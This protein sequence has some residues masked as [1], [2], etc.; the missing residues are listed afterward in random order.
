LCE[1]N[2]SVSVRLN[3]HDWVAPTASVE[4][5]KSWVFSLKSLPSADPMAFRL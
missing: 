5:L 4:P 2:K 1:P 3:C